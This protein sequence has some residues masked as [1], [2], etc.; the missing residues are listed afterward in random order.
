MRIKM[1]FG[2][3]GLGVQ[4]CQLKRDQAMVEVGAE[5]FESI[6]AVQT[7]HAKFKGVRLCKIRLH[8]EV[9]IDAV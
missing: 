2:A 7:I 6:V 1:A 9:T 3:G 8:G 4:P 5:C